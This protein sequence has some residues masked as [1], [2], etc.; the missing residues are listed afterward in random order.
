MSGLPAMRNHRGSL[1]RL[2][3]SREPEQTSFS[4]ERRPWAGSLC[5]KLP[6]RA[7]SCGPR[8]GG[9]LA[10]QAARLQAGGPSLG[11]S[12]GGSHL[13]STHSCQAPR[14]SDESDH[15]TLD[16]GLRSSRQNNYWSPGGSQETLGLG[17]GL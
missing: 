15:A 10:G 3:G 8:L 9:F 5:R 6:A 12:P 13:L 4:G 1:A 14:K 16:Q 11:L 7:L 2:G 17:L